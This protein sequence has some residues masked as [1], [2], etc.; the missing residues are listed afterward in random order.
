M[1]QVRPR[2][3]VRSWLRFRTPSPRTSVLAPLIVTLMLVFLFLGD[4]RAIADPEGRVGQIKE[5]QL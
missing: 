2:T 1:M 4:L 5:A 3:I